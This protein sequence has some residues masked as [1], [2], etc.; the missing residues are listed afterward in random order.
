MRNHH[1]AKRAD[2]KNCQE[3]ASAASSWL[4]DGLAAFRFAGLSPCAN[5]GSRVGSRDAAPLA[6]SSS[7]PRHKFG[8]ETAARGLKEPRNRCQRAHSREDEGGSRPAL[9]ER[10]A[11]RGM[12]C[13]LEGLSG[14]GRSVGLSGT[15]AFLGERS[16]VGRFWRWASS[17]CFSFGRPCDLPGLSFELVSVCVVVPLVL[18]HR[19]RVEVRVGSA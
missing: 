12:K 3:S 10:R 9:H 4:S 8:S 17:P 19:N 2:A 14:L 18:P 5:K 11:I 16:W 13:R 15:G 1:D 7:E 6:G